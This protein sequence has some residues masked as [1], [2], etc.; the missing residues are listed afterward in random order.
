MMRISLVVLFLVGIGGLQAHPAKGL[1]YPGA[2]SEPY[3]RVID[4]KGGLPDNS[5]NDIAQDEYGF[6]W[7]GSWSG[8]SR[9]DGLHVQ[10]FRYLGEDNPDGLCNNMVRSVHPSADGVWVGTDNG[11]DFYD[12]LDG[13][14]HSARYVTE[15]GGESR[16]IS[17]RVNKVIGNSRRVFAVANG[18]IFS[19][20]SHMRTARDNGRTP[21]FTLLEGGKSSRRY[22][23]IA[24][25]TA[26]RLLALSDKGV[27]LFSADGKKELRHYEI[28]GG[29]DAKMNVFCDTI[30]GR[31]YIGG[32]FGTKSRAL[33]IDMK[34]G[35]ISEDPT[36]F[37]PDNLS[38]CSMQRGMMVFATDG[39]GLWRER[40]DG[41]FDNYTTSN[42]SIPGDALYTV[43]TDSDD[44]LW[45]GTYRS[46][47]GYFSMRL[48]W[49]TFSTSAKGQ[50]PYDIVTAVH[51]FKGKIYLGLDG[52][53]FAEY[54]PVTRTSVQY[55]KANSSLP[56]DN[57]VSIT[58]D[59]ERLWLGIYTIG[60][61]SFSPETRQIRSYPLPDNLEPGN[62]VWC[63]CADNG[64]DI[65]VGGRNL[66]IFD[67][68]TETFHPVREATGIDVS[69]IVRHGSSIWVGSH[70]SGLMKFNSSSRRPVLHASQDSPSDA[71]RLP[72]YFIDNLA[73]DSKGTLWITVARYGFYSVDPV[74]ANS[75]KS[76][77]PEQGLFESR[78]KTVVEDNLGNLWMGTYNGLY[79]YNSEAD[80][81]VRID[82]PRLP[83]MFNSNAGCLD[84]DMVLLGSTTGLVSFTPLASMFRRPK[85]VGLRFTSLKVFGREGEDR[86]LYSPALK[87]VV[88]NHD[89]NFFIINFAAPD[90]LYPGRTRY[91]YRLKGLDKTW[92]V[93]DESSSAEYTSV[94]PGR[95]KFEVRY[96]LADGSWSDIYSFPLTVR[97]PWWGTWWAYI[98]MTA[99]IA[100][101]VLTILYFWRE[102]I[103]SKQ[104]MEIAI[105]ERESERKLNETKLDFFAKMSHELR[106]PVF[107]IS[108]QIEELLSFG[109]DL[110]NVRKSQL[111]SVY[112]NSQ[113]LKRI[114][115]RVIDFRK[116]DLGRSSL[117]LKKGDIV[118]FMSVLAE[119]YDSLCQQK[120]ITFSFDAAVKSLEMYF[121]SDCIDQIVSNL[122]TNA[123]KYTHA[124]GRVSLK[125]WADSDNF[126]LRVR[127]NGIG[128]RESMQSQIFDPYFRTERGKTESVG[129]G[130]GLAYVRE[131]VMLHSGEISLKSSEGDGSTFTVKLP[132][133]KSAS[134]KESAEESAKGNVA[135][136]SEVAASEGPAENRSKEVSGRE[137]GKR[138]EESFMVGPQ[139][140]AA[141]HSILIVEDDDEIA[142]LLIRT[143][144]DDFKVYHASDGKVA[145]KQLA[146]ILPDVMLTDLA[147][148]GMDGHELITRVRGNPE[149][150]NIRIVVLTAL[151]TE[152]D[153]VRALDEGAD[154]YFTKPLSLR[155][156]LK[157]VT[158]MLKVGRGHVYGTRRLE[159]PEAPAAED[160]SGEERTRPL[161]EEDKKFLV[162]CRR[163]VDDNLT[164]PDFDIEFLANALAMSHSALYKRIRKLTG[165]SLVEFIADYRICKA[166]ELFHEGNTNVQK[167]GETV[168]FRDAKTFRT[169]FKRKMGMSP[170]PYIQSL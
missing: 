41:G 34:S 128:I 71:I 56:G 98:I 107:L 157:Q 132:V 82:D 27:T 150:K 87:S 51:S 139:N 35:V 45:V 16:A 36:L 141:T 40:P 95:Y 99:V 151:N 19:C 65:W 114:I 126:Y 67:P 137:S 83:T 10:S 6:L 3:F 31:I 77:G 129:D 93:P 72:N 17:S 96:T 21:L 117:N 5:I 146:K 152:E 37:V 113:K 81:F 7:I 148:P 13:K 47:M 100:G 23:D 121:D 64:G 112:R 38:R 70:G 159:N 4:M 32:G 85:G 74:D 25:F 80:V 162:H 130:I 90:L 134:E 69:A 22:V 164:N 49:F 28:A 165:M 58:D 125:V 73:V 116:V 94:P 135:G 97:P 11:L 62:T 143:F 63:V 105:I 24:R 44:D 122:I 54:D 88:L 168:G 79:R 136:G 140:P 142:K 91:S 89:Q 153:M 109:K 12:F 102:H 52:G 46:G 110:I 169:V 166:I 53:G 108:A 120:E 149:L 55:S 92:S 115:N 86:S 68:E 123:Y 59:G 131:L 133:I 145:L 167:V 138:K 147:M 8:L 26:G 103:L 118:A 42:S 9:Y 78:V 76:Y 170:K 20:D 57:V 48:N 75:L 106:T 2:W 33:R 60:L 66:N 163:I 1:T 101:I 155:V 160:S 144:A 15:R 61:A 119:D 29:Y 154:A 43:F 39:L 14:F 161:T 158:N 127:D 124:G 50:I 111:D 156:L 104:K 18:H 84:G 30:S